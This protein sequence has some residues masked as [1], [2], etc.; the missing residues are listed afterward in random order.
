M[1]EIQATALARVSETDVVRGKFK[2]KIDEIKATE[3][4]T[5]GLHEDLEE[6]DE[7]QM[8][9]TPSKL[10][11]ENKVE[12]ASK[13][14]EKLCIENTIPEMDKKE[15]PNVFTVIICWFGLACSAIVAVCK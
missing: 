7:I 10:G 12:D 2:Q 1:D 15:T 11:K 13:E 8:K 4:D 3:E 6:L 9:G 14:G 5:I